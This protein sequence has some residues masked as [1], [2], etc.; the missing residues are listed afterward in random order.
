MDQCRWTTTDR[1]YGARSELSQAGPLLI[2]IFLINT[3][4]P[5]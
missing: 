1:S 5:R 4:C 2:N 3:I